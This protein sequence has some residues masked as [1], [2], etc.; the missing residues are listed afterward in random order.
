MVVKIS[1]ILYFYTNTSFKIPNIAVKC[2]RSLFLSSK[3]Y[4]MN[5]IWPM[6]RSTGFSSRFYQER[7]KCFMT[8]VYITYHRVFRFLEREDRFLLKKHKKFFRGLRFLKYNKFSRG[9]VLLFLGLGLKTAGF[10]FVK[11]NKFFPLKKYKNFYNVR[12]KKFHFRKN[13]NSFL[14]GEYKKSFLLRKYKNFFNTSAR[15]FHFPKYKE[16]FFG[17]DFLFYGVWDGKCA[18]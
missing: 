2:S 13:K 8:S 4:H 15:K 10:H 18:S 6:I 11:Y 16:V 17:V 9:G 12:V 1:R 5:T 3:L 7:Y 14:L